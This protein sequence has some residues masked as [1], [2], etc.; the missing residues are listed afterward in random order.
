MK[1]LLMLGFA[2]LS[3]TACHVS[4]R[5]YN[6]VFNAQGQRIDESVFIVTPRDTT[7]PDHIDKHCTPRPRG[8]E[9]SSIGDAHACLAFL[10]FDDMGEAWDRGQLPAAVALIERAKAVASGKPPIVMVFVHGWKNNA[11]LVPRHRNGN[12]NGFEGILDYMTTTLYPDSPVVGIYVAWRGDLVPEYWPLRRQL[13]YFDRERAAIRIPG[14]SMTQ[15]LITV[16]KTAHEGQGHPYVMMVGHSFGALVLER[17]LSQAMTDY[18]LR[19]TTGQQTGTTPDGGWPDLVVFVNS[20]AAATEGKQA[21]DFLKDRAEFSSTDANGVRTQR[22]LYVS[23]SSLGDAATRFALPIGHGPSLVGFKTK[24]TLRRYTDAD[25]PRPTGVDG[26]GQYYTSTVAHMRAL[27]S[28]LILEA[29]T[30]DAVSMPARPPFNAPLTLPDHRTYVVC[31]K[32]ERWND[33]PYWAM[34][35]PASIVRD[36]SSIFTEQLVGLIKLFAI[37]DEE[38]GNVALRPSL[39]AITPP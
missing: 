1:R 17:A 14:A 13:S 5:P 25:P 12:V 22:P 30:C 39:H 7:Q 23:V 10:E 36:H 8:S 31:E 19:T 38:M 4:N 15:A 33:T 21:L 16:A 6:S 2:A 29:S 35:M 27:Q 26:Q 32:P 24:G 28:H 9:G 18:V 20:A 34:Q 37:S 11:S 3:A